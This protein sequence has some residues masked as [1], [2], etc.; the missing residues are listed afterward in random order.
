VVV[1][2]GTPSF[3]PAFHQVVGGGHFRLFFFFPVLEIKPKSSHIV[4]KYSTLLSCIPSL[5]VIIVKQLL[6][7]TH[8]IEG[9]YVHFS[10]YNY[11]VNFQYRLN[12]KLTIIDSETTKRTQKPN[13]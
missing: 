10:S 6:T 13:H 4:G 3:T 9:Y 11:L 8:T 12:S 5:G 2:D 7:K 1:V